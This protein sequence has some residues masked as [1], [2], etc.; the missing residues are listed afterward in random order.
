MYTMVLSCTVIFMN[1][2]LFFSLSLQWKFNQLD[3]DGDGKLDKKDLLNFRY[4]LMP[5]EHCASDFFKTCANKKAKKITLEG[6]LQ[7]L[8]VCILV[9]S[10]PLRYIPQSPSVL[11]TTPLL[12][13]LSHI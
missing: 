5:L 11:T 8:K 1:T 12:S 9:C 4:S 10:L 2:A 6:W 13:H 7:C 3:D